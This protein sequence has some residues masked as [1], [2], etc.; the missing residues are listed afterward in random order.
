VREQV[1]EEQIPLRRQQLGFELRPPLP[2]RLEN[3]LQISLI[4]NGHFPDAS[5]KYPVLMRREFGRKRLIYISENEAPARFEGQI[6]E[7][8]LYFPGYRGILAV[9]TS[10]RKTASTASKSRIFNKMSIPP[11]EVGILNKVPAR[12]SLSETRSADK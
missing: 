2:K 6:R 10:S 1:C 3:R 11:D 5:K 12:L 8:S 4:P 9:E 7:N